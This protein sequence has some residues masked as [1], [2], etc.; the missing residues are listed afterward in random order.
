MRTGT[1][2]GFRIVYGKIARDH[3]QLTVLGNNSKTGR[4]GGF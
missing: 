1:T 3:G 4:I 2:A